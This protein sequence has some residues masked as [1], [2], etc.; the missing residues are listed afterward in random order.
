MIARIHHAM[1]LVHVF[2][3]SGIR[4]VFVYDGD[5]RYHTKQATIHRRGLAYKN[6]VKLYV[7]QCKI[8][9]NSDLIA[10]C[11][12]ATKKSLL[13]KQQQLLLKNRNGLSQYY[14]HVGNS[15]AELLLLEVQKC[16][17]NMNHFR[18]KSFSYKPKRK[19]II[20]LL[21]DSRMVQ[22]I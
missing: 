10:E 19:L 11:E 20:P 6:R 15:L 17:K 18:T 8:A 2:T 14:R 12:S 4:V 21:I 3:K 13:I 1:K 7:S 5:K 22:L 16:N 9:S